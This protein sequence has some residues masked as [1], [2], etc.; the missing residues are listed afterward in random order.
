[1]VGPFRSTDLSL[2]AIASIVLQ[3]LV[4]GGNFPLKNAGLVRSS[5]RFGTDKLDRLL[6]GEIWQGDLRFQRKVVLTNNFEPY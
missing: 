2:I 3:G 6:H 5:F 4:D 1:M